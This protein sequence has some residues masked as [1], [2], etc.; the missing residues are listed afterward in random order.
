MKKLA[1]ALIAAVLLGTVGVGAAL[2]AELKVPAKETAPVQKLDSAGIAGTAAEVQAAMAEPSAV[3]YKVL[4]VTDSLPEDRTAY[5]DRVLADWGWPASN[6][7]LL[8]V[9]TQGNNDVRFAMGADFWKKGV[10]VEE[11][12]DYIHNT[13][14]PE[15]R[16]GDPGKALAAFMRVVNK[17]MAQ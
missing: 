13:Y 4:V 6:E 11:M 10:K 8:V 15:L 7:L 9:F 5:L 3:K 14:V 17:R 12:V 16:K 1:T 2:A